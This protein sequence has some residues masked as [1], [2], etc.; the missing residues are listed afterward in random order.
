M[1]L[2]AVQ[3]NGHADHRDV[4]HSQGEQ[5]NLPPSDVPEAVSQPVK[6]GVK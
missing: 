1:G 5:D 6:T 2:V 4:R 3:K